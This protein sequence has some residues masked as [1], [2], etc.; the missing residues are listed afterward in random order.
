M[1]VSASV[2]VFCHF[3]AF[4]PQLF[5]TTAMGAR[6]ITRITTFP[7]PSFHHLP[8]RSWINS[9]HIGICSVNPLLLENVLERPWYNHAAWGTFALQIQNTLQTIRRQVA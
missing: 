5:S 9:F 7:S 3:F 1:D 4:A 8:F 6:T 2:A